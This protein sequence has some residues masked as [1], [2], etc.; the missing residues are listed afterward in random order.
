VFIR[1]PEPQLKGSHSRPQPIEC[2]VLIPYPGPQPKDTF[3][4]ITHGT[5][6]RSPLRYPRSMLAHAFL[7]PPPISLISHNHMHLKY[8]ILP[9][10]VNVQ[11]FA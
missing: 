9:S 4:A 5:P 3:R 11:T 1:Y 7:V 10:F 6:A 8:I 2:H